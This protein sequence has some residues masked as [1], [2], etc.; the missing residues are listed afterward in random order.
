MIKSLKYVS[1]VFKL[2]V[3]LLLN[4]YGNSVHTKLMYQEG[5]ELQNLSS[6]QK[7][8]LTCQDLDCTNTLNI[9]TLNNPTHPSAKINH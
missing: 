7:V 6:C 1:S 8:A 4:I 5:L 3:L 2:K 9:N